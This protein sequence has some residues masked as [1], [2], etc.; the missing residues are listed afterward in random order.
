M[1]GAASGR[2]TTTRNVY[3]PLTSTY[4]FACPHGRDAHVPLSAFRTLERLPGAA[5]PAVYRVLFA[6]L[7]GGDHAGLVSHDDLDWAPLGATT[8]T[9]FRNLMTSRDEL[10]AT[11]L[12]D[13]AAARIG[14]GQWPWSFY[15]YLE[16]R[17]RPVTPSAF[18]LIAPGDGSF[19]VAVRCPACAAVSVNLVTREHVDIPFWNDARVGVVGHVFRH[20][21]LRAIEEFRAELLSARFDERRL[22]LER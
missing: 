12:A 19:G 20:D 5:H 4:S 1:G 8:E 21:E 13:L 9:T 3:D 15:C 18:A 7:C 22:D 10:L 16:G 6:C 14:A 17:P 11:E 2:P